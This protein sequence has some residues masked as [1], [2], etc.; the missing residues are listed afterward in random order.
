MGVGKALD[1]RPNEGAARKARFDLLMEGVN[2]MRISNNK[3]VAY[4]RTYSEREKE[5]DLHRAESVSSEQR[6]MN[7]IACPL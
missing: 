1:Q 7:T 5:G 2:Q 3:H 6:G 4:A